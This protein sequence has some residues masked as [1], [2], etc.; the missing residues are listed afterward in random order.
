MHEKLHGLRDHATR[1]PRKRSRR[2]RSIRVGHGNNSN[3]VAQQERGKAVIVG[4][5]KEEE[6]GDKVEVHLG[7][8]VNRHEGN[9]DA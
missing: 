8:D 1:R 4:D 7:D 2:A 5:S 9:E 6:S 3:Y